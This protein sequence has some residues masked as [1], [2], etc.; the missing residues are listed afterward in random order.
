MN[1][2][3]PTGSD[4]LKA[5]LSALSGGL[6]GAAAV[7]GSNLDGWIQILQDSDNV[8]LTDIAH[9]L[10]NLQGY[11]RGGDRAQISSSLH[12]LGQHTANAASAAEGDTVE[13]LHQLGQALTS[14]ANQLRF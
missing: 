10:E 9:E 4:Q 14:A 7:A 13:K 6:D 8:A 3:T 1:S 11:L 5:T 2:S 12:T